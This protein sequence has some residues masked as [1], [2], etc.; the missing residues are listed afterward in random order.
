MRRLNVLSVFWHRIESDSTP[1]EHLDGT[2]STVS[3]FRDHIRFLTSKYT[4][5]SI[6]EFLRIASNRNLIRSYPKPPILLGFD[7]GFKSVITNAL[8]IL[9]EFGAPAVF[10]IAGEILKDP[11][12]VP[13]FV[14]M[15][16]VIRRAEPRNVVYRDVRLNLAWREDQARLRRL[17]AACFSS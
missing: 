12:F 13:W 8:P 6:V 11:D 3:A 16:H 10:F 5:I 1:P 2:A 9:S 17:V 14:E 7:D 15:K 4:P